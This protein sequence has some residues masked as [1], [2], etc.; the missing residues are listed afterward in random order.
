VFEYSENHE[1]LSP[2]GVL[3]EQIVATV[4]EPAGQGTGP[5]VC[6]LVT[7]Q[8]GTK[9]VVV[10]TT[11]GMVEPPT[12]WALMD[13]LQRVASPAEFPADRFPDAQARLQQTPGPVRCPA[14]SGTAS[15]MC[16][17]RTPP[18]DRNS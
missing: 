9:R 1:F 5:G 14:G 6:W 4:P 2:G 16:S 3:F 13:A 8:D 17:N 10:M 7:E 18:A 11:E 12:V 15:T